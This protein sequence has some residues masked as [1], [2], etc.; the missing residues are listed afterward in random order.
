MI[1]KLKQFEVSESLLSYFG[2]DLRKI[3]IYSKGAYQNV[4][5][6]TKDDNIYET[7]KEEFKVLKEIC[8]KKVETF[9]IG[10]KFF[11]VLTSN[12]VIYCWGLNCDGQLG[13]KT[14]EN[15]N[16][17]EIHI[18]LSKKN[19]DR[20]ICGSKHSFAISKD[21]DIY[22][23]GSNSFGQLGI[24]DI[25]KPRRRLEPELIN[26]FRIL[27]EKVVNICCG[28][29]HSIALTE[30]GD[31]YRWGSNI[32]GQSGI[33]NGYLIATP[34]FLNIGEG[35]KFKRVQ[36]GSHHTLL[37]ST[38]GDLYSFGYNVFGQ[39]GIG[40]N[41]KM[42]NPEIVQFPNKQKIL[43]IAAHHSFELSSAVTENDTFFYWGYI[44]NKSIISPKET[45]YKSFDELF[46]GCLK[47]TYTQ[48]EITASEN[49]FFIQNNRFENEFYFQ[50][51]IGKGSS[52]TIYKVKNK[53]N[54]EYFAIKKIELM[55]EYR[56]EKLREIEFLAKLNDK[57]DYFVN[58]KSAWF[59]DCT[60]DL[61]SSK[62]FLLYFQMELCSLTLE[63][64]ISDILGDNIFKSGKNLNFFGYYIATELFTKILEG[65]KYLHGLEDPIIHCDLH[66]DN[67]M[68]KKKIHQISVKII[69]FGSATTLNSMNINGKVILAHQ[70]FAAFELFSG[71]KFD[72]KADIY[73]LGKIMEML[74]MLANGYLEQT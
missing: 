15:K 13:N 23:W 49:D 56:E 28:K 71:K 6:S 51:V 42:S 39:L 8:N 68:I 55:R 29:N 72:T 36:C 7:S 54:K 24:D 2:S 74:F 22:A 61:K 48:I 40:K 47:T 60:E 44:D 65:V 16:Q 57:S 73:S 59:E 45:N 64:T 12:K 19:I 69:D 10:E 11:F 3:S 4:L 50:D 9:V 34:T 26:R 37:L 53:M 17:P 62:I 43:D 63:K 46:A 70:Y 31:V 18:S 66:P 33:V 14:L 41:N 58:L 38:N 5:I 21:N 35:I 67:I 1:E 27:N 32:Y 20:I 25:T 30:N 52:G